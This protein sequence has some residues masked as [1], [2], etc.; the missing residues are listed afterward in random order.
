MWNATL[1]HTP[2]PSL[3]TGKTG[4]TDN[5]AHYSFYTAHYRVPQ[6]RIR[7]T[8]EFHSAEQKLR[9][10]QDSAP[11]AFPKKQYIME[12]S[13]RLPQDTK[14]LRSCSGTRAK[15]LLKSH[16]G[17]KCTP[18]ITRSSD[19]FSTV[20]PIV[21]RVTGDALCVTWRLS[22]FQFY[23]HSI[24]SPKITPLTNLAVV[25]VEGFCYC[26]TNVWR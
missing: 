8:I 6:C 26:N 23:S 1:K 14:S 21:S 25:M 24:S 4:S 18:N 5:T 11:K 17:I 13:S 7:L 20:P 3:E 19:S 16:L 2:G 12:Y 15:L 10:W 9:N 22:Y